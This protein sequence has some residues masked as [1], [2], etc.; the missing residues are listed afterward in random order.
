LADD[1]LRLIWQQTRNGDYG[2]IIRLL[3]LTGQRRQE[4]GGI[5]WSE[6]DLGAG[7]WRIGAMRTKNARP[8]D[9]PLSPAAVSILNGVTRREGRDFVFGSGDG[10]FAGWSKGKSALDGRLTKARQTDQGATLTRWRLH[11]LR[12]TTA[13]RMA[14]LGVLPHVIEAILNHISGHKAG[15][16][17]VYN[18]SSYTAEKRM[19][20]NLW[21]DHV[22][23]LIQGAV[24]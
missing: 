5:L 17:G 22:M 7:L 13:T 14:D 24:Q 20:L 15:V 21:A 11:D 3:I 9:V 16:A 18:R 4:V 1:E 23:T 19:A 2:A 8:H 6:L 10:S 12:R